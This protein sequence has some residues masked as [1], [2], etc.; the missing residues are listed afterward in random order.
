M[1]LFR[2]FRN[3]HENVTKIEIAGSHDEGDHDVIDVIKGRICEKITVNQ[4]PDRTISYEARKAALYEAWEKRK[5]E[6]DLLYR[7]S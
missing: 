5:D 4:A 7:E 6:I 3:Q 1:R 2:S